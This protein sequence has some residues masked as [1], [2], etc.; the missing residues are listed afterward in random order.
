[1]GLGP[2]TDILSVKVSHPTIND[3]VTGRRLLL[4]VILLAPFETPR[5]RR[6]PEQGSQVNISELGGGTGQTEAGLLPRRSLLRIT[7]SVRSKSGKGEVD[8]HVGHAYLRGESL[9]NSITR[10][11]HCRRTDQ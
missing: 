8:R 1:M 9:S 10:A 6:G 5:P 4:K 2:F 11:T 7:R 3:F